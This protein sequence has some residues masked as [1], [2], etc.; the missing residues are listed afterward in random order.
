MKTY[1]LRLKSTNGDI[2]EYY[3]RLAGT[4]WESNA[5]TIDDVIAEMRGNDPET[6]EALDGEWADRLLGYSVAEVDPE[7]GDVITERCHWYD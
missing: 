7:T 2:D 5:E 4:Y 3:S 1:E 6:W